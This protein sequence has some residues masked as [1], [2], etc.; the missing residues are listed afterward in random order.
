LTE[1]VE[2]YQ[3]AIAFKP[4][5]G[6]AY[7]NLG[8]VLATQN[9][10]AEAVAAFRKAIELKPD[11]PLAHLNLGA[12]LEKKGDV[13]GAIAEY[14]EAVRRNPD[15]VI[16]RRTLGG[17]LSRKGDVDG[18]IA[19]CRAAV[20]LNKHDPHSHYTLGVALWRK[21][22]LDGAIAE[23]RET[24]RLHK[25]HSS[26][27]IGLGD[28]FRSKGEFNEALAHYRRGYELEAGPQWRSR[29]AQLVKECERLAELDGK[30]PRALNGEAAP[31][32]AAECVD[33]A[34]ICCT[35]AQRRYAAAVRFYRDAFAAEPRLADDL[36]HQHRY[37]AACAAAL[38]GSGQGKDAQTLSDKERARL[39]RQALTWLRADLDAY[40]QL[41]NK[42]ADK[43]P[44]LVSQQMQRWQRDGDFDGVR[45]PEALA[46]LPEAE[47]QAW[48]QLWADVADTLSCAQKKNG[49]PEKSGT[50]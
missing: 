19:E 49:P 28:A 35:P 20:H 27:Y 5:S 40:D 42:D 29:Y 6:G 12:A 7:L 39:R 23:Y 17:A 10:L 34:A 26:A 11:C 41:L 30:L 38:A 22:D 4:D 33:L 16:A 43:G 24:I 2:V 46:K 47:R 48:Q 50:K 9:K 25:P 31:G 21:G 1:A 45:G 14:R 13:E 8:V 36:Q 44:A 18:G 32:D 15:N 37:N 3:K